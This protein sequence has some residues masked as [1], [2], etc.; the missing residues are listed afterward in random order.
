MG[1]GHSVGLGLL[2][3]TTQS[4]FNPVVSRLRKN[5]VVLLHIDPVVHLVSHLSPVRYDTQ[6]EEPPVPSPDP[7]DLQSRPCPVFVSTRLS[8]LPLCL[9]STVSFFLQ[10]SGPS[11]HSVPLCPC[12]RS[13]VYDYVDVD[14][15]QTLRTRVSTPSLHCPTSV[16]TLPSPLPVLSTPFWNKD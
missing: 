8:P 14:R 5:S 6:H 1:S 3:D 13:P 4:W 10:V 2:K 11:L 15:V 7:K 9:S 12:P 16:P